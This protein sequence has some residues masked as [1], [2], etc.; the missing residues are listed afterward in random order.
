MVA[1]ARVAVQAEA[2]R[3][4]GAAL[5]GMARSDKVTVLIGVLADEARRSGEPA[6]FCALVHQA[7]RDR[8]GEG[9]V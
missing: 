9:A 6:L 8:L 7:L 1:G 4:V 5:D 2:A 3:E